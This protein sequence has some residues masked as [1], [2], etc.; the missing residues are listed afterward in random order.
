METESGESHGG[1]SEDLLFELIDE[2]SYPENSFL[3]IEPQGFGNQWYVVVALDSDERLE[4]SIGTQAY[5]S[6]GS[7]PAE[8]RQM[9]RKM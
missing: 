1:I 6:I 3:T 4:W 2:L 7:W 9:S 8:R 5:Q